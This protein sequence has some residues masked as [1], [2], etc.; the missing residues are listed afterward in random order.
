M[1]LEPP[2]YLASLQAN[3]RQ[4]PIPW[5]GA[6]RAGNLTSEQLEQIRAVDK[7]KPDARKS[8]VEANL[9]G[10]RQLFLGGPGK[11]SVLELT[12]KRLDVVQYILVLLSD[13][14]E[15]ACLPPCPETDP[16]APATIASPLGLWPRSAQSLIGGFARSYL[17]HNT[18]ADL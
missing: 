17:C 2:T 9:D 7:V 6:V 13:L 4:R 14:V 15:S 5:E 16:S 11:K 3:V 18:P 12:A 10:Y 8:V 1:S